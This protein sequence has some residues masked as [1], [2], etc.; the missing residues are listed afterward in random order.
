[1]EAPTEQQVSNLKSKLGKIDD[2]ENVLK[3]RDQK[4]VD[5]NWMVER[6]EEIC[7]AIDE[8]N[9]KRHDRDVAIMIEQHQKAMNDLKENYESC[10]KPQSNEESVQVLIQ[11]EV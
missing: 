5:L 9:D 6:K 7:E 11:P 10:T 3:E 1:M 8:A 4:I 2:L